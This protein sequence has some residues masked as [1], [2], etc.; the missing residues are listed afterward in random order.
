MTFN[1]NNLILFPLEDTKGNYLSG[2]WQWV[3]HIANRNYAL[4]L[5]S[6]YWTETPT[7]TPA[8]LEKRIARF[9]PGD[10]PWVPVIPN[11]RLIEV[12]NDAA[13]Y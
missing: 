7:W 3:E 12:I 6:L 10:T 1:A 8:K 13:E 4:A 5:E 2:F 9:F 11:R